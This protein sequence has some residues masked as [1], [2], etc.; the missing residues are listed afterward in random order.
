MDME[1]VIQLF[2]IIYRIIQQLKQCMNTQ[3]YKYIY[4]C[5]YKVRFSSLILYK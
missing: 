3:I 5:K 2:T 4:I 1:M